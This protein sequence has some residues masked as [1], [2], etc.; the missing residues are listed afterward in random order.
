MESGGLQTC[1]TLDYSTQ[2]GTSAVESKAKDLG[3]RDAIIG[4]KN[5]TR[6]IHALDEH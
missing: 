6:V 5:C 2:F 4:C 3:L 1:G